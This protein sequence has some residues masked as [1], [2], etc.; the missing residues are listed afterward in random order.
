MISSSDTCHV[1]EGF[2]DDEIFRRAIVDAVLSVAPKTPQQNGVIMQTRIRVFLHETSPYSSMPIDQS[3]VDLVNTDSQD[4]MVACG[5]PRDFT[6]EDQQEAKRQCREVLLT[7]TPNSENYY[8]TQAVLTVL[9][10]LA[11]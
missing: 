4:I 8:K 1:I 3:Y 6:Y 2:S 5:L 10:T 7:T 9:S 11:D